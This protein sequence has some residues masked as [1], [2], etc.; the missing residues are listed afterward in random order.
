MKGGIEELFLLLL[1]EKKLQDLT[2][3]FLAQCFF[4]FNQYLME[5]E[6]SFKRT[7]S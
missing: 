2:R 4:K 1:S 5:K 3:P 7:T 6:K